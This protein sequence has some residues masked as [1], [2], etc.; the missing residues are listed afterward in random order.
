VAEGTVLVLCGDTPLLRG[1]TL[2]QA[3]HAHRSGGHAATVLTAELADPHG[4]GRILRD[5]DGSVTGIVEQADA[6]PTQQGI[7]VINTGVYV[8]DAGSLLYALPLLGN[9][10]RQGEYYLTDVLA[11]LRAAGKSVG[12]FVVEDAAE[13]FGV[14]DRAQLAQAESVLQNRIRMGHMKAGVTFHLPETTYVGAD[15]QIGEDTEILPGCLL[16]GGTVIGT[17]C[18]VGPNTRLVDARLDKGVQVANSVVVESEIGED[19]KVGPFAFLRPGSRIGRHVKIGDFVEIKKSVIGDDTKISHLTY[20]GDAEVGQRVNL[21]CGVVV[22]NYDGRVKNR[23]VIGDDA[24]IGCNVNL[25]SP[26]EVHEH[27]YVAAGS[28]IT[29]EVPAFS[30]GIARSRQ[31]VKD[32]WVRNKGLD[33]P[34][35]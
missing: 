17:G 16:E 28:T 14:N 24:F 12:A 8:F 1:R 35:A 5:V 11:I 29:D 15:V 9:D 2:A 25:V 34:K 21:G 20:V 33:K 7:R 23:T 30:L 6:S 13:T 32:G 4:Y 27:A 18:V 22:V 31:V 19:T 26:V 10:N 3:F